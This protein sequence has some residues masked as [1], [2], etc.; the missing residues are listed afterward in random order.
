[1]DNKYNKNINPTTGDTRTIAGTFKENVIYSGKDERFSCCTYSS[2]RI[3]IEGKTGVFN[4]KYEDNIRDW[5]IFQYVL[6][7]L[8]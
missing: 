8:S 4:L 2:V 5:I 6:V 7:D 3:K 1:M